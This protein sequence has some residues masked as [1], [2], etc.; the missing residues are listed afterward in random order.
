MANVKYISI[1]RDEDG[2]PVR[3]QTSKGV[4][5]LRFL[6]ARSAIEVKRLTN[7]QDNFEALTQGQARFRLDLDGISTADWNPTVSSETRTDWGEDDGHEEGLDCGDP[8]CDLCNPPLESGPAMYVGNGAGKEWGEVA[9][10]A[11]TGKPTGKTTGPQGQGKTTT[12]DAAPK[13]SAEPAKAPPQAKRIEAPPPKTPTPPKA[14]APAKAAQGKNGQQQA[15]GKPDQ[16]EG[17]GQPPPQGDPDDPFVKWSEFGPFADNTTKAFE[18][19]GE[20]LTANDTA[21]KAVGKQ[22]DG[23]SQETADLKADNAALRKS[24]I[25]VEKDLIAEIKKRQSFKAPILK[26]E[27]RTPQATVLKEGLFHNRFPQLLKHIS[28]GLHTFL[29][30]PP[31]TGKSHAAG[32]AADVL[33]WKFGAL[34]LG[35][36]TPESRL[37]GG[38]DANGR[39]H[40]PPMVEGCIYA[41]ENP[42]SGFVFCLD[43]MD[44]GHPGILATLNS[45]LANGWFFA[46]NGDKIKVGKNVAFIA[47]ANTYGSGPTAEFSGRNKID[48]ATLD[49]FLFVP[50][51]TDEAVETTLVRSQ[52]ANM[53]YGEAMATEWLTV[54]RSCRTKVAENRLK[55]HVTMRG[56]VYGATLIAGGGGV[57][58]TL[59]TVLLDKLPPD[60]AAK[61]NPL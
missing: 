53:K 49:R 31:G 47:A 60:Q 56:A 30:G 39:F 37:M 40:I 28:L 12:V 9:L 51:E 7:R 44:N 6:D 45:L 52:F 17:D 25:Q 61:I 15:Q 48:A 5:A 54:W 18:V 13:T 55:I 41:Q 32:Q 43:E 29:P 2:G 33:G 21:I 24:L 23:V 10:Q 35:P 11:K 58:S 19:M 4:A 57:D 27:I 14:Q 20:A 16:G 38:M 3:V 1:F 50:W 22:V 8:R 46:P 34:S 42:D 26:L 59:K 36:T